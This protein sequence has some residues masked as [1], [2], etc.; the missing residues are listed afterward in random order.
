[1][2]IQSPFFRLPV[3]IGLYLLSACLFTACISAKTPPPTENQVLLSKFE[4]GGLVAKET[5]RGVVVYLPSVFFLIGSAEMVDVAKDKVKFIA[6][7]CNE[8]GIVVRKI[9]LEGHTDSKGDDAYNMSLS[10]K[11][12]QGTEATLKEYG[13]AGDRMT[14]AWF[15]ETQ[16]LVPNTFADGTDNPEGRAANRRVEFII[17]NRE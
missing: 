12:A 5:P 15:G 10:K 4:Q 8:E 7:V 17:L 2:T 14:T 1:M 16:P 9:V 3:K 6:Q 13:L 11:R